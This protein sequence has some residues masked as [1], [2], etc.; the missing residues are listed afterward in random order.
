M[1]K[2]SFFSSKFGFFSWKIYKSEFSD[3]IF[4]KKFQIWRRKKTQ[5]KLS[6][7]KF[8]FFFSHGLVFIW[9]SIWEVKVYVYSLWKSA[10]CL[11]YYIS[12]AWWWD[13]TKDTLWMRLWE[14]HFFETILNVIKI[15]KNWRENLEKNGSVHFSKI[16]YPNKRVLTT[17]NKLKLQCIAE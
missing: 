2:L 12:T 16:C 17:M 5:R 15:S 6:F 4:R 13:M 9:W 1:K 3:F 10:V 14:T 11:L 7:F 8:A